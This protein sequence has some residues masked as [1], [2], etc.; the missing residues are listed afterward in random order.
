MGLY[1]FFIIDERTPIVD[2]YG[3]QFA[4]GPTAELSATVFGGASIGVAR[5]GVEGSLS[6]AKVSFLPYIMPLAGVNFDTGR[7]CF[8]AA[9]A[10]LEFAGPLTVSGPSGSMGLAAYAGVKVCFFGRCIKSEKK[11]FSC[12]A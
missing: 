5:A 2:K 1:G 9:E 12:S 4:A 10:S 3:V 11:V 8:K 7:G 6:L